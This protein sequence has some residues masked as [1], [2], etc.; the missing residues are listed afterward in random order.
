MNNERAELNQQF[1]E[2]VNNNFMSDFDKSAGLTKI[3]SGLVKLFIEQEGFTGKILP[4]TSIT[5]QECI[6]TGIDG[7]F[8]I[9]RAI[10]NGDRVNAVETGRKGYPTGKYIT[11]KDYII[12]TSYKDSE[13]IMKDTRELQDTWTYDVMNIYENRIGLGLQKLTDKIFMS[14]INSGLGFNTVTGALKSGA[15]SGSKQIVDFRQYHG[16]TGN[17]VGIAPEMITIM[18][19][20]FGQ[21]VN[22]TGAVSNSIATINANFAPNPQRPLA[23]A[24]VLMNLYDWEDFSE[25][26]ATDIGSILRAEWIQGYKMQTFKGLNIVTTLHADLVPRGTMYFF[27]TP[28]FMGHNFEIDPI[29]VL[30][31]IDSFNHKM[32]IR[33]QAHN[34]QGI[35]NIY[36]VWMMLFTPRGD[37]NPGSV[38]DPNLVDMGVDLGQ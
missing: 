34:G 38:V 35:G 21:K 7:S 37:V 23:A 14:N 10:D 4:P 19:Q 8:Y 27:T 3:A 26:P 2:V 25:F 31:K 18:K 28:D 32:E 11:G 36:S 15:N 9:R 16:T 30:T 33:G 22:G 12:N 13:V 17:S 29:Q 1:L 20:K 6:P 24:T 5:R